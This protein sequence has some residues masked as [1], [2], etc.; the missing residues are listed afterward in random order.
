MRELYFTHF[1]VRRPRV[2]ALFSEDWSPRVNFSGFTC[3]TNK[4]QWSS[5]WEGVADRNPYGN[6]CCSSRPAQQRY[7]GLRQRDQR[8]ALAAVTQTSAVQQAERI[9]CFSVWKCNL[10]KH[11]Y[12][13]PLAIIKNENTLL[14]V[15]IPVLEGLEHITVLGEVEPTRNLSLHY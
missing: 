1:P 5:S 3:F 12:S 4:H 11:N 8:G 6:H 10:E 2:P 13:F 15:I 7:A 9:F 14:Y